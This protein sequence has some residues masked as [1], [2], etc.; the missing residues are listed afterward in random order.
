MKQLQ[1]QT[2]LRDPGSTAARTGS[3]IAATSGLAAGN[4]GSQ[5]LARQI[6]RFGDLVDVRNR[7]AVQIRRF[8]GNQL[9]DQQA[10]AVVRVW[11]AEQCRELS[12]NEARAFAAQLI[13]AAALAESQNGR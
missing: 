2:G 4:A 7:G 5:P 10:P 12:T 8:A 6:T 13:A 3:S 9:Q 1:I 11:H